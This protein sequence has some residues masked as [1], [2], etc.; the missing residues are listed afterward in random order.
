MAKLKGSDGRSNK[1]TLIRQRMIENAK[2]INWL[3]SFGLERELD[4]LNNMHDW[5]ISKKNRY[6]GLALPIW[7][8]K[9]CGNFEVIGSKEEL[10]EKSVDWQIKRKHPTNPRSMRLK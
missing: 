1:G 3:P 8:C 2:K 7:E 10:N 9:K 4:W 5:L 6:W